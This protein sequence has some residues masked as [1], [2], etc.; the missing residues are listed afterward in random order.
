[1]EARGWLAASWEASEIG[2]RIKVY[3]ITPNGRA[4][5][6]RQAARYSEFARAVAKVLRTT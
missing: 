1:M 6:R 5:L 4:E 2:Q 3:A